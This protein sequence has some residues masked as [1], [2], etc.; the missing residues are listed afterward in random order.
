MELQALEAAKQEFDKY[1]ASLVAI[2]PQTPPNSR[3][4]VR[5]NKL[6]FPIL[7]D[8]KNEVAVAFGLR[9]R[10]PNHLI[11]LY[12][13]IEIYRW[14]TNDLPCFNA[15]LSWTLLMPARYVIGSNGTIL[16][17]ALNPDYRRRAKPDDLIPALQQA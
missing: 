2:S 8:T 6:T 16:Y 3:K 14:M 9:F 5:H 11:E 10:L 1:G 7:S 4:S 13:I 12:E 15:D 17:A